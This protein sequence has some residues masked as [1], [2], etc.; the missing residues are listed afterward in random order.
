MK[1]FLSYLLTFVILF[2][3]SATGTIFMAKM[4]NSDPGSTGGN[5]G[6]TDA[7]QTSFFTG[8][9][10]N[11]DDNKQFNIQGDVEVSYQEKTI[12]L[13][14]YANIDIADTQ[15]IR[16]EGFVKTTIQNKTFA[17]SLVFY[18]NTIYVSFNDINIKVQVSDISSIAKIIMN[19]IPTDGLSSF[20]DIDFEAYIEEM[21]PS[22]MA[23][24]EN[25]TEETLD[26]GDIKNI[27][28]IQGLVKA[29]IITNSEKILKGVEAES[30]DL[31]GAKL[32]LDLSILF[33]KEII[34]ENPETSISAKQYL[35]LSDLTDTVM[36]MARWKD[37]LANVDIA[38]NTNGNNYNASFDILSNLNEMNFALNLNACSFNEISNLSIIYH[39]GNVYFNLNEI[40]VLISDSLLEKLP[41]FAKTLITK[42][43]PEAGTISKESIVSYLKNIDL[44]NAFK[45][46]SIIKSIRLDE[47][48]FELNTDYGSIKADFNG[49]KV[50]NI[51]IDL[52][53]NGT[54]VFANFALSQT[55]KKVN[56]IE[57]EKYLDV[58]EIYNQNKDF[59]KSTTFTI[60]TALDVMKDGSLFA[61]LSGTL[62]V[63]YD[64]PY[65]AL[66]TDIYFNENYKLQVVYENDVCYVQIENIFVK[67]SKAQF[68]EL[69][70]KFNFK[71]KID[72]SKQ[73][74]VDKI[75]TEVKNQLSSFDFD[76]AL[77][78]L[79]AISKF[80]LNSDYI[81]VEANLEKLGLSG[82]GT[83]TL[84]I[85]NKIINGLEFDNFAINGFVLNGNI[86]V[87]SNTI[88]KLDF[89]RSKYLDVYELVNNVVA[90]KDIKQA[91]LN[92]SIGMLIDGKRYEVNADAGFNLNENYFYA[93][94]VLDYIFDS[95]SF[96]FKSYEKQIFALFNEIKV[97]ANFDDIKELA[98]KFIDS[99]SDDINGLISNI[100]NI[101]KEKMSDF[102]L[103]SNLI[104]Q[105]K[106]IKIN[107]KLI[108]LD[109]S[110]ELTGLYNNFKIKLE[111]KDNSLSGFEIL[112]L[113]TK[114]TNKFNVKVYLHE[115]QINL[116]RVNESEY[117]DV[118]KLVNNVLVI[119]DN[120]NLNAKISAVSNI[121]DGGS[122]NEEYRLDLVLNK[123]SLE[124]GLDLYLK[125]N[126]SQ[127]GK[128]ISLETFVQNQMIYANFN[129][130]KVKIEN[131][132]I[133]NTVH[134]IL[135]KFGKD[136]YSYDDIISR[137][138]NILGG[139]KIADAF[140]DYEFEDKSKTE[141]NINIKQLLEDI[142]FN[143]KISANQIK[144]NINGN[145]FEYDGNID[146]EIDINDSNI[147]K[148]KLNKF[149]ILD[150]FVDLDIELDNTETQIKKVEESEKEKYVNIS[151]LSDVAISTYETLKNKTI[152]GTL[153]IDFIFN[154]THN[155][156]NA[157]YGV[158]YE[159]KHLAGYLNASFNG[160]T[161]NV[162]YKDSVFYV[163]LGG[164][165]NNADNRLQ[166]KAQF[167]ELNDV[168]AYIEKTANV[169]INI[170]FN[171]IRDALAG[172]V[173][174]EVDSSNILDSLFGL[175]LGFIEK[176]DFNENSMEAYFKNNLS[177]FV[178]Y[179]E[180][181][182]RVVFKTNKVV[183][184]INCESFD[185]FAF[186]ELEPNTYNHYTVIT[187]AI[188]A[189]INTFNTNPSTNP[190]EFFANLDVYKGDKKDL[191]VEAGFQDDILFLNI[192]GM[193][194][195]VARQNLAEIL[196]YVLQSV[197]LDPELVS[198]IGDV[199]DAKDLNTENLQ[200]LIPDVDF[201]NPFDM[202]NYLKGIILKD[203]E[204]EI[205]IDSAI[206]GNKNKPDMCIKLSTANNKISMLEVNNVGIDSNTTI[207]A[208]AV[209]E[210]R[211]S[212]SYSNYIDLSNSADLVRAFINTSSLNSYR[213]TGSVVLSAIGI[214]AAVVNVDASVILGENKKPIIQVEV[215][216]Y[217]LI[218][219]INN[220]NTNGVG[221]I[222]IGERYRT[223]SVFYKDGEFILKTSD[224][225]WAAYKQYD[226]VTKVSPS[227]LMNN[228][229]YYMQW[230]FGFTGT[231]QNK[232]NEAIDDST[233]NKNNAISQ[234]EFDYSDIITKYEKQ[235]NTHYLDINLK[236][237]AY[238]D[239]IGTLSIALTTVNNSNTSN[240]DYIGYLD[241]N[242]DML[243]SAIVLKTDNDNK[244]KLSSVIENLGANVSKAQEMFRN[245]TFKL[246]GE[247]LSEGGGSYK[248]TNRNSVVITLNNNGGSGVSSL[249][250][251]V[252]DSLYLPTP[253]KIIDNSI[254]RETYKFLGYYT[255][256]N[257]LYT[258]NCF[259]RENVTLFAK[260]EL[261]SVQEYRKLVL[262]NNNG[263]ENTE[264]N[265]LQNE[266]INVNALAD[267][268]F[269]NGIYHTD[270]TFI[271]WY[272]G[273]NFVGKNAV[274][275]L[276]E[277]TT[278]TAK[279]AENTR[280]YRTISFD[281]NGKC[282]GFNK[283]VL[284]GDT[285]SLQNLANVFEITDETKTTFG[286][287]GWFIGENKVETL[288]VS[289]DQTLVASWEVI[290][291][292]F[293]RTIT[294][295]HKETIVSSVDI[296][297]GDNITIPSNSLLKA[298][299]KYYLE[300]GY[301]TEY[302]LNTMPDNDI[303]VYIRNKYTISFNSNGGNAVSS[304][305][306]YEGEKVS[307]SNATR[308]N[309]GHYEGTEMIGSAWYNKRLKYVWTITSYTFTGWKINGSN[310]DGTML[311]HDITVEASWSSTSNRENLDAVN[312]LSKHNEYK[313]KYGA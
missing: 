203:G 72:S 84:N 47:R 2:V 285:I 26:N 252:G 221:L 155:V 159:N 266:N 205:D 161:L 45:L 136:P 209:F 307:L 123:K 44:E 247:Y 63:D 55:D 239:Q 68:N 92:L 235:G 35:D 94:G 103:D 115:R 40:Y 64:N 244:L 195:R 143:A 107:S 249:N 62:A 184:E 198:F 135:E 229:K 113:Q 54:T 25:I 140:A 24:L 37:I 17:I 104:K 278:L 32:K 48:G 149:A 237:L 270:Y 60:D 185:E 10:A 301:K 168:V 101:A 240:K 193:K 265:R 231:I 188:D 241:V 110:K 50:G 138:I 227:Y 95:Y 194:I 21:M 169:K 261:E 77:D 309:T 156:V 114:E 151:K 254:T 80:K 118:I 287:A 281:T 7:E 172:A 284:E 183:A 51:Q 14:I 204:F 303:V 196:S 245:S 99:N 286:F 223:M 83:F 67:M 66:N 126:L 74:I 308:D 57:L 65:L 233:N 79:K 310:F 211:I 119:E 89:D 182:S 176:V 296:F 273:D 212:E 1:K 125:A 226:R 218:G 290:N 34:I 23:S 137:V 109:I 171:K 291:I 11:F 258:R 219:G 215:T 292:V 82:N 259:P 19:F 58:Y 12:P 282:E 90:L 33:D 269:D 170:D 236:K 100:S 5:G 224:E 294:F 157:L 121:L 46:L 142:F 180:K 129:N 186:N 312:D 8:I 147:S 242:L 260:W 232:I 253:T 298:D 78:K 87:S 300:S 15:N 124:S 132:Q 197:G 102:K 111:I 275:T 305:S 141:R 127:N 134:K 133:L 311:D 148:I 97:K 153:S 131:Y 175:D 276:S 293:K 16:V 191:S 187:N 41:D 189:V 267:Y 213:M 181:V 277:N 220:S 165:N 257:K 246:D 250:G 117:L 53:V 162:Y 164:V 150:R 61:G 207:H 28:D 106:N 214:D 6:T 216:K 86:N 225:K 56:V 201:G 264:Y 22:I 206:L 208:K 295:M 43:L 122:Y 31:F 70:E 283:R 304:I 29:G 288:T 174:I 271:G 179:R 85:N 144:L 248:Q 166:I 52:D 96:S 217:P 20:A 228:L 167:D 93:D 98:S 91:K 139:S 30:Y 36:N 13:N 160:V 163:D 59:Y 108:V 256:D 272:D 199:A 27:L 69:L 145:S 200:K 268:S 116:S 280:Y 130:L 173:N 38:V 306:A 302:S 299:T 4:S 88:S 210:R 76:N 230:I 297:A 128:N 105:L 9:L 274:I 243:D 71:Q 192:K 18:N 49:N 75:T 120:Q 39:E 178:A 154:G 222:G 263:T 289:E 146:I 42:F 255:A 190:L 152:S 73:Q 262:I 251:S 3:M 177:I 158:K 202:L 238:N 313:K 81:F 234:G 112:G 279:F